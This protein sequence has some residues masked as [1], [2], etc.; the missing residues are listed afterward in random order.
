MRI[1]SHIHIQ[2]GRK[3]GRRMTDHERLNELIDLVAS[4]RDN[5]DELIKA[6]SAIND[7]T[8]SLQ[9]QIDILF[10]RWDHSA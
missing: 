10:R 3:G 2:K 7:N 6:V 4:L 9:K 8:K 1:L 5:L